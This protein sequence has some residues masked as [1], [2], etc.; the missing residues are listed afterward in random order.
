MAFNPPFLDAEM[1]LD[2]RKTLNICV[3]AMAVSYSTLSPSASNTGCPSL[4]AARC[5]CTAVVAEV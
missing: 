4:N 5:A 2:K 3:L 1:Q